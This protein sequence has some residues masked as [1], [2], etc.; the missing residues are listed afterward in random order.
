[1]NVLTPSPAFSRTDRSFLGSWWWT[2]DRVLLGCILS[3]ALF[4]VILITT[5]SPPVAQ[6]L[7]IDDYHFLKR[8][9]VLLCPALCMMLGIS[10]LSPRYVWRLASI[11]LLVSAASMLLVLFFG[12]EV[13]GARRWISVLHFSLQPSEFAKPAFIIVSAWLIALQKASGRKGSITTKKEKTIWDILRSPDNF[14]GYHYAITIYFLLISLL[15]MQPDLGMTVLL[16]L[17]F[18]AQIVIAGLRFRFLALLAAVGAGGLVVAYSTFHHVR[19]RVDRFLYPESGDN[20]QVERSLESFR[21]GGFLGT[22]PGQGTE[23]LS[24]PDAHA[25]FIFS[26]G[27]EEF[28]FIFT[29]LLIGLFLF[30]LLRGLNRLLENG[31]MFAV[32]AVGGLLTMFGL[33]ALIH[34]GSAVNLLP[35][36]GMTLPFI[37]YGGSS[38]LAMGITMGMVL[39]LTRRQNRSS[40]ARS[41]MVIRRGAQKKRKIEEI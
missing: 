21:N 35:A 34:M 31:D 30:I 32:L 12:A 14:A 37:S 9:L 13:K 15:L 4:G 5:A 11:L 23:K 20:Y 25:D 3:L 18:A 41:G 28:G 16:T 8:H 10:M 40:V 1:M 7:G 2:V 6:H 33:Q 26:V 24:L 17:V 27:G 39:A 38:I 19:S 29:A 36:K 22:G